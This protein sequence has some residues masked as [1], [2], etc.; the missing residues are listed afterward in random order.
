MSNLTEDQARAQINLLAKH[1]L[2][3]TDILPTET[4]GQVYLAVLGAENWRGGSVD[5]GLTRQSLNVTKDHN[6]SRSAAAKGLIVSSV[7]AANGCALSELGE[8]AP[9]RPLETPFLT[10]LF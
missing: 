9:G 4:W 8:G 5:T 6:Q 7:A 3:L 1:I 2:A 10:I